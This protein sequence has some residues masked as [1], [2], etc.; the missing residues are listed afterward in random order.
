MRCGAWGTGQFRAFPVSK[1]D[2]AL[3]LCMRQIQDERA[4]TNSV[5]RA[6]DILRSF[7]SQTEVLR[8]RDVVRRTGLHK[9][10]V[11]RML[12]V[13]A[14]AG[15]LQ[16]S[17]PRGYTSLVEIA[18]PRVYRI[19][20]AS[21]TESSAFAKEVTAGIRQA[22]ERARVQ[23]V[24]ADN[25][26]SPM[27]ALRNADKLAK[28][29]VNLVI[30][31]QTFDSVAPLISSKL[32]QAGIPMI[33]I[34]I[35]HPG[36]VYFGA[37]NYEAGLIAGRALG[38]WAARHW[39]GDVEHVL[40]IE[41]SAAGRLPQ[42]RLTGS[43]A[44]LREILPDISDDRVMRVE[45][46]DTLRR[47]IAA[48]RKFVRFVRPRRVLITAINDTCAIGAIRAFEESGIGEECAAV[49][50]GAV[51]DA[52]M[53]MRRGNS[54]L[55][56]SV[57]FFPEHYGTAIMKLATAMLKNEAVPPAVFTAH[58]LITPENVEQFYGN[59]LV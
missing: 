43:L 17:E 34:D 25:R 2:L 7:K 1:H 46:A 22:A 16:P 18:A 32:Q 31:F 26:A 19:G 14:E 5:L 59:E 21:Q 58:R 13:L 54:R 15:L 41:L 37:N 12:R 53:E 50:H 23:L 57:A 9:A 35:P 30:E 4:E 38:R 36:A 24:F 56:G 20:Y 55:I 47:S 8:V 39:N 27:V 6:C 33:A 42:L 29:R 45:G 48:V 49:G 10:T 44:G 11:S 28:E 51:G 52:R 40:L 3:S